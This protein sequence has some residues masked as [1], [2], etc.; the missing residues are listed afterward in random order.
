MALPCKSGDM[1]IKQCN[2]CKKVKN[3]SEFYKRGDKIDTYR[4]ICKFCDNIA[5]NARRKKNGWKSEKKRQGSGTKH[6]KQSKI[7]SQKHR[8]EMS[9]MYVRSLITKKSKYLNS[10]D[11]PDEFVRIY[12]ENLKLKRQLGLTPKLKGSE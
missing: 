7:N 10:K 11:I 9:P 4:Y 8:D 1:M 5:T 3:V 6:S 12:R 2:K